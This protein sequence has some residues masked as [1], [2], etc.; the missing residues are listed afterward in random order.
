VVLDEAHNIKAH[1]S[2]VSQ[3]VFTLS[4]HSR[5]CLTGTPLQVCLFNFQAN[6]FCNHIIIERLRTLFHIQCNFHLSQ[7]KMFTSPVTWYFIIRLRALF[8]QKNSPFCIFCEMWYPLQNSLEDLYSLLCFLRVEPWCNWAW[9]D[10]ECDAN[11]YVLEKKF[12]Y[13]DNQY[14]F[15]CWKHVYR[16]QKL[17]Q[18]PYE[19]GDP[20]SL[21]LVK[22]ILRTV[23]LRRTKESKDKEGR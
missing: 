13:S 22:A 2:Q 17:I 19:N 12:F 11:L 5:W 15:C 4:S 6:F 8:I 1:R 3:A 10:K 14:L 23:M 9:Y 7:M 21:K 16:W 18:R 20:R